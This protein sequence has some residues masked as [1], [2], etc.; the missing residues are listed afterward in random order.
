MVNKLL[1]LNLWLKD[2]EMCMQKHKLPY[3]EFVQLIQDYTTDHRRGAMKFQL[4]IISMWN[5]MFMH[6]HAMYISTFG[7]RARKVK[8][9]VA[10]SVIQNDSTEAPGEKMTHD[11]V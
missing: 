9:N 1:V 4:K 6:F 10:A 7:L 2:I 5:L 3:L 8:R 11:W